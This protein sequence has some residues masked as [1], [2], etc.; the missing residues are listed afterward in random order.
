MKKQKILITGSSG[1]LGRALCDVLSRSYQVFG[2]DLENRNKLKNFLVCDITKFE[3]VKKAILVVLPNI[4]IHTAA[5]TD[6][7]GCEVDKKK[8]EVVNKQGAINVAKICQDINATLFFISTDYIFNG[9]KKSSYRENDAPSPLNIYGRAKFEAEEFIRHNLSEY[10]IV[11]TSWLYGAKGKNFV[12]TIRATAQSNS[13]LKVIDDQTG[14]PTYVVD[15]SEAIKNLMDKINDCPKKYS[16]IYHIT[17]S[18][19]C[20]WYQ[21]AK[22]ITKINKLNAKIIPMKSSQLTRPAK[23]PKNS[24]LSNVKFNRLIHKPMRSWRK[25]LGEYLKHSKQKNNFGIT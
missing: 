8:S 13:P 18:G 24:L 7:D 3:Q 16:G 19:K 10:F 25:A 21:F 2:I 17:N 11:R 15:L 22:K 20:S 12:D 23:R 5:Y 14:S 9:K 6:V 1:M 4:I